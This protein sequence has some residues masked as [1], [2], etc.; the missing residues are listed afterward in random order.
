MNVDLTETPAIL[1]EEDEPDCPICFESVEAEPSGTVRANCSCRN[2]LFHHKCIQPA[3]DTN[4]QCPIC[5]KQVTW[6]TWDD[7][8]LQMA[9]PCRAP[10]LNL[11]AHQFD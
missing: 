8:T 2:V 1:I 7:G 3:L 5:R 11:Y 4:S 9:V 10:G 6:L